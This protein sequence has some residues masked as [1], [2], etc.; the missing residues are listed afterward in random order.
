MWTPRNAFAGKLTMVLFEVRAESME[1]A[2]IGLIVPRSTTDGN[3]VCGNKRR[4]PIPKKNGLTLDDIEIGGIG[5]P[6]LELKPG[7]TEKPSVKKK[8]NRGPCTKTPGNRVTVFPGNGLKCDL[9][10]KLLKPLRPDPK[11]GW[12][13][14]PPA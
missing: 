5:N 4:G 6:R 13:K 12:K 2:V 14:L 9:A 7:V 10:P 8:P 3:T 1:T 11:C